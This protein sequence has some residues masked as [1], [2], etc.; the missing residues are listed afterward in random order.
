MLQLFDFRVGWEE[1]P[2]TA[3][4]TQESVVVATEIYTCIEA[5][6]PTAP[7]TSASSAFH[8]N[9]FTRVYSAADR[10]A[11]AEDA[12][13][14]F[15]AISGDR[16][17][18]CT[19]DLLE[20]GLRASGVPVASSTIERLPPLQFGDEAAGFRVV[21]TLGQR[22]GPQVALYMD[23]L[24]IRKGRV[25]LTLGLLNAGAPFVADVAAD[26]AG[27]MTARA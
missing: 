7:A 9:E 23:F 12:G 27:K 3:E 2:I 8:L 19:R 21:A 11:T 25:L 4:E 16:A 13:L 22:G 10:L 26:L 24:S 15:Q 18:D 17:A 20:K 14:V 1:L 5:E 6:E